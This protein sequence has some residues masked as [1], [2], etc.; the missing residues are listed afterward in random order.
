ML[1]GMRKSPE[2]HTLA[3]LRVVL[4]MTQKEMADLVKRSARTIQAIELGQLPLSDALGQQFARETAVN[5]EWLMSGDVSRPIINSQGKPYTRTAFDQKQAWINRKLGDYPDDLRWTELSIFMFLQ[6]YC[7]SA[8]SAL[9][10]G[11]F[12]LFN[13][14]VA[15]SAHAIVKEFG[16]DQSCVMFPKKGELGPPAAESVKRLFMV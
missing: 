11:K 16:Q 8:S 14:K 6:L 5:L 2:S 9:K 13:Y 7:A 10:S 15:R 1:W 4:G 12:T 3:I